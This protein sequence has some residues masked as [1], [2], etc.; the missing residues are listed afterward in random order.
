LRKNASFTAVAMLALALGIGANTAIFSVVN[1]VLLRPLAYPDPGRLLMIFETTSEFG[2]GSVAY[3]NFL[4]WR[5]ES[6]SI[7]DMG[8]ARGQDFNFTEPANPN[9]Y[10]ASTFRRASSRSSASAR[11]LVAIS[12]LR[13]IGRALPAQSCS[14]TGSG[15]SG[16][17]QVTS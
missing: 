14:A 2:Q 10:R 3:S 8:V 1:G 17:E 4:D 11:P 5:R 9:T 15:N 7:I 16:S 12:C 6:R 13:K